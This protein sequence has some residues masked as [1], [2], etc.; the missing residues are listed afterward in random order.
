[1]RTGIGYD[2]HQLQPNRR[3]VIGG[4]H[5]PAEWGA[6]GHSDGDVLYHAAAD[7]VLGAAAL[8]DIGIYFPSSDPEF[9]GMDSRLIIAKAR[10]LAVEKGL[11]LENLDATVVLESPKLSDHLGAM[12][13]NLAAVFEVGIDRISVKATT[14]DHLGFIGRGEGLAAIAAVLLITP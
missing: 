8:G 2:A 1:M 3:L 11:Q 6:A 13:E 14:T 5:I 9:E 7:A 4:V 12:R 10:D